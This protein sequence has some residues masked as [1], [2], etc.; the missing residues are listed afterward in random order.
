MHLSVAD[1]VCI[2][3]HMNSKQALAFE[4]VVYLFFSVQ[5]AMSW[6]IYVMHIPLKNL[7]SK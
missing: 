5:Q 4:H 7:Q 3:R 6:L 2:N 1:I